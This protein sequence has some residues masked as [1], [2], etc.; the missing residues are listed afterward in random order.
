MARTKTVKKPDVSDV[1][2]YASFLDAYEK[3]AKHYTSPAPNVFGEALK[4]EGF[5]AI[6]ELADNMA[7]FVVHEHSGRYAPS[8][9]FISS[10]GYCGVMGGRLLVWQVKPP[11][12]PDKRPIGPHGTPETRMLN[13][14]GI[15]NMFGTNTVLT[16]DLDTLLLL[17]DLLNMVAER[18]A[19]GQ[20]PLV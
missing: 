7:E 12:D 5:A 3:L 13:I 17:C 10:P 6:Q 8:P 18:R 19:R 11:Q 14:D 2:S 16:Q 20:S 4:P 1:A 15:K 9:V